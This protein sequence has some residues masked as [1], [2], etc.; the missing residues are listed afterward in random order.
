MLSFNFHVCP[1]VL[2]LKS[3][4][5]FKIVRDRGAHNLLDR[6]KL[7]W[8]IYTLF[9]KMWQVLHWI[10]KKKTGFFDGLGFLNLFFFKHVFGWSMWE[11]CD[12]SQGDEFW[13]RW[14]L[15]TY[16]FPYCKSV[17]PAAAYTSSFVTKQ[18]LESQFGRI[19]RN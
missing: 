6:V 15:V 17:S 4:W 18:W 7:H 13:R 16:I 2:R 3:H 8:N 10:N 9:M 12:T 11:T 19:F 14:C 1:T 5:F